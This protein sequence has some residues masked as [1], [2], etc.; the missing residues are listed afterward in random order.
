MTDG[1]TGSPV[2]GAVVNGETSDV[3]GQVLVTFSSTGPAGVKADKSDS[4]RSNQ[5]TI[6]VS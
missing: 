3:N 1:M 6:Q 4:I 2:A 5:L